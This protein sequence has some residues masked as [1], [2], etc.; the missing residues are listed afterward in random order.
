MLNGSNPRR[1]LH[2]VKE[3]GQTV[4]VFVAIGGT[5]AALV[6]KTS[7]VKSRAAYDELK[8][9]VEKDHDTIVRLTTLIELSAT[10]AASASPIEMGAMLVT[11][12]A[13]AG[14]PAPV[15][16]AAPTVMVLRPIIRKEGGGGVPK[17]MPKDAPL[18]ALKSFDDL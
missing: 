15:A 13:D 18:R 2:L 5:V 9:Q 3:I 6:T 7:T 1:T 16:S 4:A 8:A 10:P 12:S 14:P 17:S 11:G